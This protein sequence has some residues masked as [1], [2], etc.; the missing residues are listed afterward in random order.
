MAHMGACYHIPG[1]RIKQWRRKMK[2]DI[3]KI[4]AIAGLLALFFGSLAATLPVQA[5]GPAQATTPQAPGATVVVATPQTPVTTVVVTQVIPQTGNDNNGTAGV[6]TS[7][8]LLL[9]IIVVALVAIIIG[10]IARG[11]NRSL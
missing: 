3:V 10:L 6:M 8:W 9:V 1:P 2:K 5:S 7:T 4:I 11:S